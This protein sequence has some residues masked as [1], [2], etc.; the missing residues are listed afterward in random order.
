MRTDDTRSITQAR[1]WDPL[2]AH[3]EDYLDASNDRLS[4]M[5][6]A[7]RAVVTITEGR[8]RRKAVL[9][10]RTLDSVKRVIAEPLKRSEHTVFDIYRRN[11]RI[12]SSIVSV[13]NGYKND[14]SGTK[15]SIRTI[16]AGPRRAR[17]A[18]GTF[19]SGVG[20][21]L[22]LEA[23]AQSLENLTHTLTM[24]RQLCEG[25]LAYQLSRH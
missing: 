6:K 17:G 11:E 2:W 1:S 24:N 23:F 18:C 25:N 15:R 20:S 3:F 19:S 21:S 7:S 4:A 9:M 22:R 13:L 12:C 5:V 14:N 8:L 10:L 16:L